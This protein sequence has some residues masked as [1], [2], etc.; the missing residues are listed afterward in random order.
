[1]PAAHAAG[2]GKKHGQ[3][4]EPQHA[5]NVF[6]LSDKSRGKSDLLHTLDCNSICMC[7]RIGWIQSP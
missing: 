4:T 5:N 2:R 6:S 7:L 1:M 3:L